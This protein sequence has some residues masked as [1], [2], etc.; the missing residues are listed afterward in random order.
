MTYRAA[1]HKHNKHSVALR[2]TI[3]TSRNITTNLKTRLHKSLILSIAAH[4]SQTWTKRDRDKDSLLMY[5]MKCLI[6][7]LG[8]T[9]LDKMRNEKIR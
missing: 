8:V 7:I 4:G 5:D 6:S 3:W 1:Y 2:N 9:R